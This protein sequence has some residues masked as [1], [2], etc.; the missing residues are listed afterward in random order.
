MRLVKLAL[1]QLDFDLWAI[2]SGS[3][4]VRSANANACPLGTQLALRATRLVEKASRICAK[5]AWK[6]GLSRVK[7]AVILWYGNQTG[8]KTIPRLLVSVRQKGDDK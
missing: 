1:A 5:A 8:S 7:I 3:F 6:R 2:S 4:L